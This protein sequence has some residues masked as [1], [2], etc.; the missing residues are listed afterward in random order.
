MQ[1]TNTFG[2]IVEV[3]EF[4]VCSS[5]I[6]GFWLPLW[7][8]PTLPMILLFFICSTTNKKKVCFLWYFLY[9]Y[10][11]IYN[12]PFLIQHTKEPVN[13]IGLYSMW[14]YSGF[15]SVNR[16]TFGPSFF[17]ECRR[18]T[19]NSG[20]GFHKFHY[21]NKWICALHVNMCSLYGAIYY[22]YGTGYDY[23]DLPGLGKN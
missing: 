22:N 9:I 12:G 2:V 3:V 7:Y 10:I 6:Y 11:Y 21:N 16:N 13:C 23:P 19:E 8:L 4:V 14:E 15:I 17:V 20:I 1:R 18:M 5:S